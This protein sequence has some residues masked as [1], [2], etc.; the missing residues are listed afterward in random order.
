MTIR[1]SCHCGA[2]AYTLDDDPKQGMTCNCSICRRRAHV[3]AFTA[4]DR[5]HLETPRDALATYMFN[6]H[7]I[8]HHFCKVCG[9]APFG[10]GTGP[11]G[12]K[13]IAVNLNCAEDFDLSTIELTRFDGA[14]V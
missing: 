1:G 10:E 6:K 2:V 7:V 13:M 12:K 14:S 5:F 11:D 9:C 8:Q 4:P 3:L